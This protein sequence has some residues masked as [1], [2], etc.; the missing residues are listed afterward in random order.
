M[1][2]AAP[3]CRSCCRSPREHLAACHFA[4]ETGAWAAGNC[5]RAC[6]PAPVIAPAATEKAGAATLVLDR[7]RREFS[8]RR[9][10][11]WGRDKLVAVSDV[12]LE[13]R[14]GETLGLVGES[15]CGK[16]T[17]GRVIL[18]LQPATAGA[19]ILKGRNLQTLSTRQFR[20]VRRELQVVFQDPYASLDPRMTI[21]EIV[22]EPLRINRIHD[23][24][25]VTR[26]AAAGRPRS[27]EPRGGGR[28]NSPAAS[29][30]A[31][32]SPARLALRPDLLILDEAVS[33]LDVSIQAQVVNLLKEL[34]KELGLSYLFISHDLSVVRHIADRVAVMYLGRIVETGTRGQ[35][36]DA[37]AHPY[38][39]ALL[40][41]IP[42]PIDDEAPSGSASS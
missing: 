35:V 5:R 31:S 28:A 41:A 29:A 25:R 26:A 20:A 37:P 32:P 11:G 3:A 6:R 27:A 23:P 14:E 21:A 34:Q 30:S 2:L 39:Q 40:S 42:K 17:L 7:V 18:G 38:T 33:A 8:I 1:R 16:S 22:A 36:F 15:G 13:I 19:I 12:S 9:A 4:D 10:K 24:G